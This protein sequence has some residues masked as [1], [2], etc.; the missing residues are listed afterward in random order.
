M[1]MH[2]SSCLPLI[3]HATQAGAARPS[4][5]T[6]QQISLKSSVQQFCMVSNEASDLQVLPMTNHQRSSHQP[7]ALKTTAALKT[8][9]KLSRCPIKTPPSPYPLQCQSIPAILFP[10]NIL[11]L[12]KKP[13]LPACQSALPLPSC[14]VLR[15]PYLRQQHLQQMRAQPGQR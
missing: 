12:F 8:L 10:S 1:S 9:L 11:H 15:Q 7:A 6:P 4:K 5:C 13:I 2:C 14:P 3:V